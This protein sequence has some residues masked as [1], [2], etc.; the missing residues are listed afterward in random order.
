[1]IRAVTEMNFGCIAALDSGDHRHWAFIR[2]A[3]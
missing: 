1:L 3:P 2:T